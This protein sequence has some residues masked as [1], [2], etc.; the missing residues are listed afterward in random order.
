[1]SLTDGARMMSGVMGVTDLGTVALDLVLRSDHFGDD[2][3]DGT[4]LQDTEHI[5][6][7]F[8]ILHLSIT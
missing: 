2:A 1:M 5:V 6:V 3:E 8:T 7:T 4:S